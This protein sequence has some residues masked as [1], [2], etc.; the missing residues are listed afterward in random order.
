MDHETEADPQ[1][2]FS[3]ESAGLEESLPPGVIRL[4]DG[5]H[6][7]LAIH[8]VRKSIEGA[9]LRM[10]GYNGSIPGS[11][12][13]VAEGT[14]IVV[15]V[16]KRRRPRHDR[17]LARTAAGEPLRRRPPRD[18]STDPGGRGVHL[19]HPVPRPGLYWYHPHI[20]ED[21]AQELGLYG[22]IL[23]GP[24]DRDYWPPADR[25]LILTLDDL[26]IEDGKI[27]P[28]SPTETSYAAMGRFGNGCWSPATRTCVD[29]S[30]RA[31]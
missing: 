22:N 10:L 20:R 27:A 13:K 28:F 4:H 30:R 23:V 12:L 19:P 1:D 21:Y 6:L 29:P 2:L 3:T 7:D 14:E 31:R 8:P 26:L 11:T 5:D 16:R 9:E 17:P 18:P 15:H 24:A 25:D